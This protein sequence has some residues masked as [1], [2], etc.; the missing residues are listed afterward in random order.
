MKIHTAETKIHAAEANI[1]VPD[2]FRHAAEAKNMLRKG[3]YSLK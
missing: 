1:H 2:D 3:R